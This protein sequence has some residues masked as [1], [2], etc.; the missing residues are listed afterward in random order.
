MNAKRV[1]AVL[2]LVLLIALTAG[3]VV[4][5]D[6]EPQ[7]SLGTRFTY[8][9]RLTDAGGEPVNDTCDLEFSLWDAESGGSRVAGPV[10]V[11]GVAVSDG[12]FTARPDLGAVFD[13]TAL[14]LEVGVKCSGDADYVTLAERQELTGAP[15]ALYA[16]NADTVDGQH[17]DALAY[18]KLTGNASTTPGTNF[19]GTTDNQALEL[20]VNGARALRL[21]PATVPNLIGGYS[22]NSVTTGVAG[23]TIGGGGASTLLNRVT[24]DYGTVGGGSNNRAGDNAGTT[25]DQ[26]SA[27]VGG[28][29]S[30]V[31]S[32]SYATVGGGYW[33]RAGQ[34]GATAGGGD[35]NH[36]DGLRATVGG[37][38]GNTAS[39]QNATVPGGH[40]N[41]AQGNDSFAAGHR[42]KANSQGCFVWADSTDADYTCSVADQFLVRANGGVNLNTGAAALQIN[43]NTA[44]HA[45]NDGAGSGLDADLLDGNHATAFAAA[46]HNH[47]GASWSGSGTG[48][49]LSGG[50]TGLSGSGTSYGVYGQSDS[51]AGNGVYG[52][53]NSATG[54]GVYGRNIATG[55]SAYGVYGVSL[56]TTGAGVYGYAVE[57]ATGGNPTY[58]VYGRS[59]G[60]NGHGVHGEATAT[61]TAAY[62]VYGKSYSTAGYGVFG[63]NSATSG[64]TYG[65]YGQSDSTAG[66]GMYGYNSATSGTTYGVYGQSDSAAGTGVYGLAA[67]GNGV[68]GQSSAGARSGVYGRNTATSGATVG[69]YGVSDSSGGFGVAGH[70]TSTGGGVGIGAW[71]S[72]GNLI[73]AY[74][75][76]YPSGNRRF[77][78]E[79]DGDVYAD[80]GYNCGRSISDSA[81]DLDES[82]IE[83]CLK[84][85]SPADFAE[86]LPAAPALEAGD[87]LVIGAD[88][89][90]ARSSQA[91]QSNAVGVYSSQPSYVGNSRYW[92]QGGYVP[93]AVSGV[94]PVKASAENG[95]IRPGDLLTT[96]AT[97]GHAMRASPLT[98][99][100]VTFYPSGVLVGKAL[101]G[102]ESGTGVILMLVTLQ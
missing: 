86:M 20:K 48:L 37:G 8:Q 54:A 10:E 15:Y 60:D 3:L 55:G 51:T 90:L 65:V 89:V 82:E 11:P 83:P 49:T 43:G 44:W 50:T 39:G 92:G 7:A 85:D 73:E 42:A 75:G 38:W 26:P 4:A 24:D 62:G 79:Q 29:Y 67:A 35:T 31:A 47:W 9:G 66:Y 30:N 77:Y 100:G 88:G 36:A 69:V 2:A 76:N 25:G 33:N 57:T 81:G 34:Y 13:G 102:L 27:T 5:Q 45:G 95:A 70:A 21:E 93:L 14:W 63:A 22:G 40:D 96:S 16:V 98:L 91:Y 6:L 101:A 56:S 32:S 1:Y 58:G 41:T 84:D 18:W 74:A 28:G 23:A 59:D 17:A 71:S 94:V 72:A 87:V 19:L 53:N 68:Y 80:G 46:S 97:P 99:N 78:V 52:Q 12:L 61:V 64:T